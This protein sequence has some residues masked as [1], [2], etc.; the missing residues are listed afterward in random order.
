MALFTSWEYLLFLTFSVLFFYLVNIRWRS[1]VLAFTGIVFYLMHAGIYVLLIIFEAR[2]YFLA[3][4]KKKYFFIVSLLLSISILVF[5]KY[6]FLFFG[7]FPESTW[8]FPLGISFFTFEFIH[9]LVDAHSGK[10]EN[11]NLKDHFAFIFFFPTIIAGPI[12][13]YQQFVP[14]ISSSEFSW[15]NILTGTFRIVIG[16]VKKIAIADTLALLSDSLSDMPFVMNASPVDIAIRLVAFSFKIYMDFSAYSD[17]ALGSAALFGIY[18][19]ENF[20]WPYL[21]RNIGDFWK[22]WHISLTSWFMDYVYKPLGGSRVILS[23]TLLNV[24]IVM[25]LSGLWHGAGWNFLVWGLYHGFLLAGY[26][27][28]KHSG[29]PDFPLWIA[30]PL[31]F[32]AVTLGWV[33]FM[34]PLDIAVVIFA[35]LWNGFLD[36]IIFLL[37]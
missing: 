26:H 33:F 4:H 19:P 17:I 11:P 30:I 34:A 20:N 27:L 16:F 21:A 22:R 7:F 3:K 32:I 9:Y 23:L 29:L 37:S 8:I 12:K 31:T 36:F 2:A 28:Y 15:D 6:R 24:L 35:K 10:I 5:F 18:L 13:R 14:Q 25:V 1:I